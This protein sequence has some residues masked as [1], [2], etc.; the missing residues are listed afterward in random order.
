[1]VLFALFEQAQRQRLF[2]R[3]LGIRRWFGR[4]MLRWNTLLFQNPLV[5]I[6]GRQL[7]GRHVEG[8]PHEMVILGVTT[9]RKTRLWPRMQPPLSLSRSL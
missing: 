4:T 9:R 2:R 1:M 8:K 3:I 6:L 5:L 7:R